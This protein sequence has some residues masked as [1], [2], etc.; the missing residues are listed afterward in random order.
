M[1]N[2]AQDRQCGPDEGYN[3]D[4]KVYAAWRIHGHI[5]GHGRGEMLMFSLKVR[6][7][8]ELDRC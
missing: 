1:S 6:G 8:K 4:G 3:G 5:V 7:D 2:E